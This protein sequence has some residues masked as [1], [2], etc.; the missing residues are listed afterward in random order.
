[1]Y[2]KLREYWKEK[3]ISEK[4]WKEWSSKIQL[5]WKINN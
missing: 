5:K 1:L 3:K 2:Q 4:D